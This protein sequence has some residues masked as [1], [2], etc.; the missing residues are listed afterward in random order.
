VRALE[1]GRRAFAELRWRAAFDALSTADDEAPL[2]TEDLERLGDAAY[3]I[4]DDD[5]AIAAWTRAHNALAARGDC[6]RAARLGYWLSLA[7]VMGGKV[8]QGSGWLSRVERLLADQEEECAERGYALAMRGLFSMFEG[9]TEKAC[10]SI[11][12]AAALGQRFDEADLLAVAVLSEGQALIQMQRAD[13]GIR[14][15]DE[16]MVAVTSGQVSPIMSGVIYCAVIL[17][18]ER[19]YDLSRAHEWTVA[20]DEWCRS[21]PELVAF[22]GQCLVHRSELKQLKGDWEAARDEAARARELLSGRSQR[23]MGRALYQQGELHRLAGELDRADEAYRRA[24]ELGF[25]PQPG[26]SLLR[27]AQGERKAAVASIRRV[28][29]EAGSPQG[30]GAGVQR[31]E[32]LGPFA[33]IMVAIGELKPA[34]AAADELATIAREMSSPFVSAR[35]A[36]TNGAVLLAEGDAKEALVALREAWTSWQSLEAPYEAARVRVLIAAACEQL[37]DSDTA[38]MHR[39]AAAAV[40]E[41]LGATPDLSRLRG[42]DHST[43]APITALS[44][45]EL[46]VLPLLASGKTNRQIAAELG[47][48]EHTVA[49]H[50][51]NI[52]DK[53][54]VSSRTAASAFA[55]EHDL[56]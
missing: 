33:E 35:A 36:G 21:Q 26:V 1:D 24:G 29:G 37:G 17:T 49:R 44:K 42:D 25:E 8:A 20:L 4:G 5:A 52:F 55:Y 11:R 6:L 34:R 15:L 38:A 19:A 13:E 51:S 43:A 45:R 3:L 18:C 23:L 50:V 9:N 56:V 53:L 27:L 14:L 54:G 28:A 32:V 31:L 10:A 2:E 46:E 41:R 7:L 48:S 22:R 30:P 40:F 12:Q 47:I 39:D 16:A